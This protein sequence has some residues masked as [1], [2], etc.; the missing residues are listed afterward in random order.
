MGDVRHRNFIS[1]FIIGLGLPLILSGCLTGEDS[2]TSSDPLVAETFDIALSGSVGDGPIVGAAMRVLAADGTLLAEFESSG[3]ADYDLIVQTSSD[4]YPLTIEARDGTDLVTN[5]VPDFELRSV[6]LE[7]S[8]S[9]TSNLTPFSTVALELASDMAGGVTASNVA[10]A[11]DIVARKLNFGL[12]SLAA[13]GTMTAEV[14]AANV[15]EM[16]RASE[17]L[18]ETIRRVRDRLA[19]GGITASGDEVIGALGSDLIDGVVDGQGG[20]RADARIAALASVVSSKVALETMAN[21]L[22]VN[23]INANSAMADAIRTVS[24]DNPQAL[25]DLTATADML[26]QAEIGI[27]AAL[28]LTDAQALDDLLA[29]AAD[30]QPGLDA[31]FIRGLLPTGYRRAFNPTLNLVA[32][33]DDA[34]LEAINSTVRTGDTDPGVN[35][36]PTISGTPPS[37]VQTNT[38][39]SFVPDAA[40]ADGDTL[41]FTGSGVPGWASLNAGTGRL[42]G[43]PGNGDVGT[44]SGISITVSDGSESATLGPFS[45]SVTAEP[46]PNRAPSIAGSPR[47]ET[48]ANEFYTFTPNASDPDGDPLTFSGSNIPDWA[49]LNTTTGRLAG[50]PDD[51]DVGS[52]SGISITVSD[53]SDSATLGPFSITVTT[54]PVSNQPPTISGTPGSTVTANS[55]Y[56]FTPNASDPDGDSLSFSGSGIPGW[57]TLNTNTGRL[58]GTPG[59]A[60]VGSYF[61]I[62]ITVTDG[63]E[64]ATLGPFSITVNAE[65]VS[66]RPPTI[67]GSPSSS[68]TANNAYSFTPN[69]SDPDGDTLSFTGSGIPGWATLNTNTGRISGTPGDADVGSY[70]GISIT[71]S[72]GSASDTLGPFSITVRAAPVSNTPPTIS[73]TPPS[74]VQ[75]DSAYSFTPNASDADGDSLTFT[76]QNLPSWA[77]INASNGRITGTPGAGD[78]NTYTGIVIT[79]SDGIDSA[80]LGPFSITVEAVSLGSVTLSW[81]APT[82]NTDG[83]PLTNLAGYRVYWGKN[84]SYP[85]SST[86][87][88]SGVTT[89]VVENLAAGT[90]NFVVRA[91]STQGVESSNSNVATKTIP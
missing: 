30:L 36:A 44:Y 39:Y 78:V 6:V 68:V 4:Q 81:T 23:G 90:W 71:V 24:P 61:G 14:N 16:V 73:G 21:Q 17:A 40:D 51:A 50:T 87:S 67:S 56:G 26:D 57:A 49:T 53:G 43:T 82:E 15:A 75:M 74:T 41:S 80:S 2:E 31:Q 22:F 79:V 76:A 25:S 34:V 19:T 55:A 63:S 72:D 27:A 58:S 48:T 7:P 86:I 11:E 88:N 42:S 1:K 85:N 18:G 64:S 65:P 8:A 12:G 52:Y 83:S 46:V 66:N 29:V 45:I 3:T 89:Y 33:G 69:A 5:L 70:S 20:P 62:S 60:D 59:N 13:S 35:S 37:A 54:T 38:A 10:Q 47:A 77:S 84:G 32:N 28:N 9:A 91:Y